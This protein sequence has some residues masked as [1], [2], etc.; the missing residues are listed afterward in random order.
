MRE[1]KLACAA[2]LVVV[3]V[4][5]GAAGAQPLTDQQLQRMAGNMNDAMDQGD[6]S[7]AV[8]LGEKIMEARP[9]LS[10]VSYNLACAHARLGEHE[11]ALGWLEKS[12]E[13]GF[14][15]ITSVETDVELDALRGDERFGAVVGKV[16]ASRDRRFGAFRAE[17]EEAEL[18][19]ILPPGYDTGVAA[20]LVIVM[21]GSGGRPGP[22]ADVHRKAAGEVGAI[23]VAPSALRPLGAGFNWTF[24]D[25][26]EWMVLH[27]LER[28]SREH[29][30]DME[31]VV[32][33]G[34][35]QGANI[36]LEVGLKHAENFAG[37]VAS[38]GHWD[39]E[40]MRIPEAESLPRVQLMIGAHDPWVR[41]F[42]EGE[43]ALRAAGVDVR[44]H[45]SA[46][47]GHAYP[48]DADKRLGEALRFVLG[49]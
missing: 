25:E 31:R 35:S 3:F 27:V 49:E 30:I 16:R 34:F 39:A 7:K 28:V 29:K 6:W 19:T 18:L 17:A 21:H 12:A 22:I 43:T 38:C 15:G 46:G 24:R 47:I 36:A 41:T 32:L 33:A 11:A 4:W 37:I 45:V 9:G 26:S 5:V 48:R 42:R 44:L 8:R 20:P 13:N 23:V 10:V 40:I 1:L 2:V 14:A